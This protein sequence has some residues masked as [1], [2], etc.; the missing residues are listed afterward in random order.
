[1]TGPTV[2]GPRNLPGGPD[3]APAGDI[4]VLDGGAFTTVQDLPG[5]VGYW[6]VGVPPSGPMDDLSHRLANLVVGNPATAAALELTGSGPTLR[7]TAPAVVAIV[8]AAMPM[9]VAGVP[10]AAGTPVV[11]S[12]GA[13]V[14]IGAVTGPGLRASLAVR[15]GIADTPYLASRSTFTLGGLGANGGR[16]LRSPDVLRV[17]PAAG[18]ARIPTALAPGVAPVLGSAW[19]IGVLVGPHTAPDFLTTNGLAELFR[20]EWV[21]HHNS[22]RTG[23]RL[24]GPRLEWARADGGEAGLHPSNIHDTGYAIGA[25]DMTGDM[26]VILGPDGP[27]LGG[28]VCPA[29]VATAE[30]W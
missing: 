20:A 14:A 24:V 27:S 5:R 30:R 16:V 21:V 19:E 2:C 17:G 22:A 25:V 7:F 29:V 10:A 15:G 4:L 1:M 11:V 28:F 3:P 18:G 23:V 6:H 26:P 13:V 8:G 12:A 9:T